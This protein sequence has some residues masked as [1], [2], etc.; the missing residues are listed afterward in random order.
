[1]I[2]IQDKAVNTATLMF[3]VAKLK[4]T[5]TTSKKPVDS[6][7]E[8]RLLRHITHPTSPGT[9][10]ETPTAFLCSSFQQC[11]CAHVHAC[12]ALVNAHALLLCIGC[13]PI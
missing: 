10:Y 2:F 13:T 9:Q 12:I 8:E 6:V 3:K 5:W 7:S 1:M 11:M 4:V